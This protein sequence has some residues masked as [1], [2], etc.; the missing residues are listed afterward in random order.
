MR[1]VVLSKQRVLISLKTPKS[2]MWPCV[3]ALGAVFCRG[4]RPTFT[5]QVGTLL[6]LGLL[7]TD[8][9][10]AA[11]KIVLGTYVISKKCF[12]NLN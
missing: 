2:R 1:T 5:S 11:I 8:S 7:F 3:L 9:K 4:C 6:K 12:L 10:I